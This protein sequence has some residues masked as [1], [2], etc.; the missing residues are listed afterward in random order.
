MPTQRAQHH[1]WQLRK[2]V[3]AASSASGQAAPLLTV[4]LS[5]VT[6]VMRTVSA[7]SERRTM[8]ARGESSNPW[9][10]PRLPNFGP[11]RRV[12][13]VSLTFVLF[14]GFAKPHPGLQSFAAP[15]LRAASLPSHGPREL[16]GLFG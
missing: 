11:T 6:K 1:R 4:R 8:V 9:D 12:G 14:Q 5:S 13:R 3:E 16:R 7:V 10:T 15:R 2:K